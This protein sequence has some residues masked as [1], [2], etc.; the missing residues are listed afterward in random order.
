MKLITVPEFSALYGISVNNVYVMIHND[1]REWIHRKDGK[2]MIDIEYLTEHQ[3]YSKKLWLSSHDYYYYF[4]YVLGIKQFKLARI[5]SEYFDESLY[6]WNEFFS[7][8]LFKVVE[9]QITNT[10]I[11]EQLLKFAEFSEIYIKKIHTRI[12]KNDKYKNLLNDL[13]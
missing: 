5:I 1:A 4:T 8:T 13:K 10:K 7:N 11:S 3:L 6:S 12:R 9:K 2:Y